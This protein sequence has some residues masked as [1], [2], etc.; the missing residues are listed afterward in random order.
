MYMYI[1]SRTKYD[2]RFLESIL[3]VL[4]RMAVATTVRFAA[5]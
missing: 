2:A 3:P 1:Y 5:S 4:F